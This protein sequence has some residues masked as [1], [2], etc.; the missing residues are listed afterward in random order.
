MKSKIKDIFVDGPI[1]AVKIAESIAQHSN[2][3]NIGAHSIFLGQVRADEKPQGIVQSINY[4]AYKEMA[5]ERAHEIREDIFT[6]F[7]LT[8]MHIYHSLG[9]VA[10]GEISLFVFTSSMHRKAAIEACAEI[11]ERIKNDLPVW[12]QEYISEDN[13]YW[14]ENS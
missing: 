8:C 12:G 7:P 5:L 1:S 11:V 3:K 13:V 9:K 4:T 6:K 14:K 2:K 10:A